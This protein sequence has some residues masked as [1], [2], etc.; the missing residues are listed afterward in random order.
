MNR[1]KQTLMGL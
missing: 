1:V